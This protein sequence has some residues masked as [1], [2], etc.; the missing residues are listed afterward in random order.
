MGRACGTHGR[1]LCCVWGNL[2]KKRPLVELDIVG[3][4][5]LN[6]F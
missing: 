2:K 3:I 6:M 5:L 1:V 4:V